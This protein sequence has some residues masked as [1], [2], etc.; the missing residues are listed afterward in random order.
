MGI[1]GKQIFAGDREVVFFLNNDNQKYIE[2]QHLPF[3]CKAA[4]SIGWVAFVWALAEDFRD[5]QVLSLYIA[6][7]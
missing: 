4:C 5:P 7:P 2:S 1:S 6:L 3:T